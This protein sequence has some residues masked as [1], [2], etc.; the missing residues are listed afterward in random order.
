MSSCQPRAGTWEATAAI[1]LL[2][3]EGGDAAV[4]ITESPHNQQTLRRHWWAGGSGFMG[5]EGR[6]VGR[7]WKGFCVP[8]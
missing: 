4:L 6:V 8:G 2:I 7:G 1:K 5:R 3:Q